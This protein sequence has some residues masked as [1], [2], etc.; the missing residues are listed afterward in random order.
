MNIIR[1]DIKNNI[2]NIV[3]NDIPLLFAMEVRNKV[4]SE[5]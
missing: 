2:S 4:K 1:Q 3:I 5:R